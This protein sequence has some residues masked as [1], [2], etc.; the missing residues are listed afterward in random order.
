MQALLPFP[1]VLE[2]MAGDMAWTTQLGNAVL[3]QRADV[4]DAVQRDRHKAVQYGYLRTN[5]EVVVG[6]GPFITI[7]G[8]RPDYYFAPV[9]DP[10]VVFFGAAAGLCGRGCDQFRVRDLTGSRISSV[11]GWSSFRLGLPCLV[12]RRPSLGAALG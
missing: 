1:S 9:Y 8:A 5:P 3:A 10:A 2:M 7:V 6:A 11:V 4:M 12:F